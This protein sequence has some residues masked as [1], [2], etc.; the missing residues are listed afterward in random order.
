MA[1]TR[2]PAGK[3]KGENKSWREQ[4]EALRSIPPYLRLIWDT[5]P[6]MAGASIGLRLLQAALPTAIL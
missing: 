6:G 2:G 5:S 4:L 1:E 3:K